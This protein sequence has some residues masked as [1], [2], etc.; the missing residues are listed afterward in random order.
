MI[1]F[2]REIIFF[3]FRKFIPPGWIEQAIKAER[4]KQSEQGCVYGKKTVILHDARILNFQKL[5]ENINIGDNCIIR[6]ELFINEYGGRITIGNFSY[7]G[8]N[9]RIWS[10]KEIIIG[11]FVQI[12]HG[13][14]IIDNNTHS[15]SF[16]ERRKEYVEIFKEGNIK[17]QADIASAAITIED[18]VWISFNVSVLKGVT[19]G[20]GA[21]IAANTVVTKDVE[22]YT[23][24]GGNPSKVIKKIVQ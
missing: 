21:I 5:K 2:I 9:S 7:I 10:S 18:D 22:P 15:L 20:K 11:N 3:I 1:N 6:G 14:N 19:I 17:K 4:I 16:S 8:E 24:V 13:V 12:S 23:M